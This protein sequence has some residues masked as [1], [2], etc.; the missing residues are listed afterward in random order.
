MESSIWKS[1]A[2]LYSIVPLI[3]FCAVLYYARYHAERKPL[4][5]LLYVVGGVGAL[6][7]IRYLALASAL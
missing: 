6:V 2:M 1:L 7:C 5:I 3:G 4:R